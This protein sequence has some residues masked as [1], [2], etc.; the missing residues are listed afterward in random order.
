M[1]YY[2]YAGIAVV[3]LATVLFG[4]V[5]SLA[6]TPRP[7][8]S[9]VAPERAAYVKQLPITD[10][11]TVKVLVENGLGSGVSIGNGFIVTAAHVVGDATGVKIKE[12]DGKE[13]TADVLWASKTYDIAL[14][15]SDAYI[16]AATLSCR[17]AHVGDTITAVGNPLGLEFIS[18]F[19]KIAGEPR[20][21]LPAWKSAFVTDITV[22]MGNSGGPVFDEN[23]D[24]VGIAV[25]VLGVPGANDSK[26][27]IGLSMVVPSSV[28]CALLGRVK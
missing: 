8:T 9:T 27:Y 13:T 24:L 1:R 20:E 5:Y 4:G 26:S 23:G 14:L 18:T 22:I 3:A 28:V 21:M 2:R 12:R 19:G 16:P 17:T 11:A 7:I 6:G 15:R 10:A 25:G